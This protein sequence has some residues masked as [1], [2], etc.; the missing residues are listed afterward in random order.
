MT[1]VVLAAAYRTPIGVFGGAFKDVPA[2]DLGA[3]LIEHIIKETGL[4]PSE[5][6]EVIIGNVLQAG[7][8]QNPARIAAMKGGL[9]E[10]VPAF[11]VNKVCGSGLKSIQL[12]Y[13]SIVTGENDIL[14]A[15]GMENMSQSPMLVNNSRF[16]FKMGHQSMVDS[17]VYDGLTDVFNQYHMGITAENLVEQ[18]GISREE[19]D[20]FAVN[21]QHKAVRAQQNGEFDSEIVPVSIPQRK[22]EPILV[23]KDEGVRENVSVEKL[24]RLRPAFKKDGTVTA[25]NA[26][27]INDGAAMMLVMSEDKAKELNIEPLAVLDG[28]G[29]HGVDPSIMGIAP[30]GAVEKALKRSK[31]ELSDIDVFELNE[32]FAAQLLAVDREL[33]LPPEKV[34]VKG[35]AIALGHPIGA[36]GA[37]VLVTLLHQLNDE[38]E[39]G[40]TSL[41][42]GGGQAIAAVVSKY[43]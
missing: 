3:T 40:L 39:T 1:R 35:G 42:I 43:K 14:L 21:S 38:V 28:F 17:M 12:A 13:Q 34:N 15:G 9:P 36:S 26:S 6:D 22:G 20:T 16:G 24:S 32:A 19:Q 29:S 8:G 7:Q 33:K 2:Y 41:C 18:Y 25:G 5:I 27:G 23:T 4:N 10:T 31:K 11:T 30:V 37:R